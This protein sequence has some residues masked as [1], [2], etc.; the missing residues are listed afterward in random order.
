MGLP[1]NDENKEKGTHKTETM[2]IIDLEYNC[3]WIIESLGTMMN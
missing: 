1:Q 3:S 2:R